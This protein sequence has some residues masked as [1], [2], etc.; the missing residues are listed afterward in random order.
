M[1]KD[2]PSTTPS[3]S[4]DPV[5]H[6]FPKEGRRSFSD[7]SR[8]EGQSRSP[9]HDEKTGYG[10]LE[11]REND[12]QRRGKARRVSVSGGDG[13]DHRSY[14]F[15]TPDDE[16]HPGTP[17]NPS[18]RIVSSLRMTVFC[19]DLGGEYPQLFCYSTSRFGL[20]DEDSKQWLLTNRFKEK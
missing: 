9:K 10:L 5:P 14:R 17:G 2:A 20:N 16:E 1:T 3:F 18:F 4:S 12:Y 19:K 8:F 13:S 6:L 7:G 11:E 15:M